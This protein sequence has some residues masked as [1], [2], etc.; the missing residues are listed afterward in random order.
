MRGPCGVFSPC[1]GSAIVKGPLCY[2]L[3]YCAFHRDVGRGGVCVADNVRARVIVYI[4]VGIESSFVGV[5]HRVVVTAGR[6][7]A[8][9]GSVTE[10]HV[11]GGPA[12]VRIDSRLAGVHADA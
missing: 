4:V 9:V 12:A 8:R 7:S 3:V 11:D 6:S 2:S 5:A 1:G 10:M